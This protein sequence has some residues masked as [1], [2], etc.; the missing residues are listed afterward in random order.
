[1]ANDKSGPDRRSFIAGIATAGA[2]A[3]AAG[4]AGIAP[5]AAVAAPVAAPASVKLPLPHTAQIA[6]ESGN[7]AAVTSSIDRW[8]VHNAGSDYMVDCLKHVGFDYLTCMPGSTFRGIHESIIN[9]GGNTKP[10]MLSALH[11]EISAAMAH[12]YAKMAGKPMAILIHNTVGLQHASMAIYNAYADRVPML[13]LIGNIADSSTRRPGVEWYHTATDVA[14]IVRGFTK[15]DSQPMSLQSFG[16]EIM[17]ASSLALTPPFEPTVVIVDADL[18]EMPMESTPLPMPK[19]APPRP[20]IADPA[21]LAD[22]AKLLVNAQNPLIV[23]DRGARS[24]AGLENIITLAES[25]Q[26]PV[27]DLLNRMCFPTNHHLYAAF[28]RQLIGQADVILGLELSD[29]F[30]VVAD[31]A[32]L[33]ERVTSMRIKP[34][35]AVVSI[36]AMYNQG[37]G[38][39]QDQQRFFEPAMAIAGDTEASMP[40]LIDAV[41]RAITSDRKAQNPARA[42]HFS[43]AFAKRR[44]ANLAQAAIGWDATPISVARMCMETWELVKHDDFSLVS[45]T[46]FQSNWPQ[47]LWDLTKFHHYNGDAGGYGVGYGMPSAVGAALAARDQGRYAVN[48]QGDGD[49]MVAPGALWTAAHHKIPLL[50]IVHNNRAWHQET[51]HVQRMADRRE[52]Q[53]EHAKVGTIIDNPEIDYSKL[54]QSFG[55]YADVAVTQPSQLAPALARALKVVKSGMPALVDVVSQ[56]R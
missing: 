27:M 15:Y 1:V 10:E 56:P 47:R 9:Y 11:E 8:H 44:T 38:N 42:A 48:F 17:K 39:F 53:P 43:D 32:D 34:G 54:A 14:S 25:L 13:I 49:L 3:A 19:F 7:P 5:V 45:G 36:N 21:A 26:I 46:G 6:A 4:A 18:A 29:L 30:G 22:V 33:P 23:V 41:N 55:V 40:Y 31:V 2:G 24:Q 52:R 20:S 28:D 35:C 51:M 50:T 37:A 16:E 12:G